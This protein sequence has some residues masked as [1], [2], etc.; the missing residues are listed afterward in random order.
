[1]IKQKSLIQNPH[2]LNPHT[3]LTPQKPRI[4]VFL[5]PEPV[6]HV[7]AEAAVYGYAFVGL[8]FP[9]VAE[10]DHQDAVFVEPGAVLFMV[11][12]EPLGDNAVVLIE[13]KGKEAVIGH[14][15]G[16]FL[17]AA[18]DSIAAR[19]IVY[20]HGCSV[21]DHKNKDSGSHFQPA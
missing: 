20:G 14:G 11:A 5:R 17:I 15:V 6:Q 1:M 21:L 19:Q 10:V 13:G 2:I 18:L 9:F 7:G 4:P 8:I 3:K 16:R 12:D